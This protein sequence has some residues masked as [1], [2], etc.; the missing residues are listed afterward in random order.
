MQEVVFRDLIDHWAAETPDRIVAVFDTGEPAWT[1]AD[2][3][4]QVRVTARALQRAGVRQGDHV[5][6]W[7]ENGPLAVRVWLAVAYLGAVHVPFNTAYKGGLL[8]HAV[9][10]SEVRTMV[11][12]AGLAERLAAVDTARLTT[13]F[14]EATRR[15]PTAAACRGRA[16][17]PGS[18][19]ST[20]CRSRPARWASSCCAAPIPG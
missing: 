19:T 2:L 4:R 14:S 7:L 13:V 10:L 6:S 16:S 18:S 12:H 17:R 15:R 20:T 8:E 3:R 5:A 11:T 9:E 1:F